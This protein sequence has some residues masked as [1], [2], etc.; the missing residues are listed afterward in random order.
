MRSADVPH[1]LGMWESTPAVTLDPTQGR[2][3]INF[4]FVAGSR[5]VTVKD[6]TLEDA[7]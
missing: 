2:N 6:F 1:A 5:G 7:H 4:E 3:T